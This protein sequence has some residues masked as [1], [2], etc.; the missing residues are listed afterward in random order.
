LNTY[1]AKSVARLADLSVGQVRSYAREGLLQADRGP[2]GEYLLSFQDLVLLRAARVLMAA[3]IRPRKVRTVL[4]NLRR[5]LP[6]DRPMTGV[7]LSAEGERV[8]VRVGGAEWDPETGQARFRFDTASLQ[9]RV[10]PHARRAPRPRATGGEDAED[11]HA[12]GNDLETTAPDHAQRA[13]RRALDLDPDHFD[14]RVN[15]GRLLHE[16]GNLRAAEA[17]YR[18]ALASRPNDA[19]ALFNLAVCLEDLGATGEAIATYLEAV[20][21]DTACADA[22]YNLARLY[23][24]IGD[25]AAAVRHLKT[26]RKLTE[27]P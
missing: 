9:T 16:Q 19:T 24:T 5:Q 12:L 26:Y 14:S 8:V 1:T 21:A 13:Y 2:R 3:R 17:H 23:E 27:R 4:R 11:W 15:L 7:Q 6:T 22:Y 18:L 25:T 20:A 10:A